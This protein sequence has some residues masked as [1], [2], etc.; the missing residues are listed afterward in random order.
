MNDSTSFYP[1]VQVDGEG[2]GVV[3]QAGAVVLV[4]TVK[5]IGLDRALSGAL[6]R[7]RK[8]LAVHDPGKIVL[9]QV[10]SLAL[11]GDCLADVDRLRGQPG[12]FGPLASDAKVSRLISTL[13]KDRTAVLARVNAARAELRKD[14]WA[15]AGEGFSGERGPVRIPRS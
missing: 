2:A 10:L 6:R 4:E 3:S 12:A 1:S 13:E 9:D 15:A 8:P 5:A 7:W 11:G 14:A